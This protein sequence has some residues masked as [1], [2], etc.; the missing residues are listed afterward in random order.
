[1]LQEALLPQIQVKGLGH[2]IK[3]ADVKS[4]RQLVA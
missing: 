4:W 3:L 2:R 1:M